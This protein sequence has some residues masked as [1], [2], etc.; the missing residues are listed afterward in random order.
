MTAPASFSAAAAGASPVR[1]LLIAFVANAVPMAWAIFVG[2]RLM[3]PELPRLQAAPRPAPR[4]RAIGWAICL[5]IVGAQLSIGTALAQSL[6]AK[7]QVLKCRY[8][9]PLDAL[10]IEQPNWLGILGGSLTVRGSFAVQVSNP[11]AYDLAVEKNR[12]VVQVDGKSWWE[13]SLAPMEVPAG[14]SSQVRVPFAV[15]LDAWA[16]ASQAKQGWSAA[17]KLWARVKGVIDRIDSPGAVLTEGERAIAAAQLRFEAV[18]QS[19]GVT[20]FL[21]VIPGFEFPIYLLSPG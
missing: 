16:L 5:V 20:L 8:S 9:L 1:L 13:G 21:E 14:G 6:H 12:L 3:A 7:S 18:R 19:I 2:T 15:K 10:R 17:K 11:T 4:S